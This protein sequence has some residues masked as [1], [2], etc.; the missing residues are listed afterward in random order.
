MTAVG[1]AALAGAKPRLARELGRGKK[2]HILP[3]WFA[4]WTGRPTINSGGAHGE[5][6]TP[7]VL[8]ISL[9]ARM[10]E[11]LGAVDS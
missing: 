7:V 11:R 4:G 2:L 1:L 8:R 3:V 6:K 9:E 5:Y 10:P